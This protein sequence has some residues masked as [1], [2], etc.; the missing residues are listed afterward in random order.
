[1][2]HTASGTTAASERFDGPD[3]SVLVSDASTR[4]ALHRL[5][6]VAPRSLP[7]A[8]FASAE[9]FDLWLST[10]GI[11]LHVHEPTLGDGLSSRPEAC[12][13][14][15]W[16]AV[17]GGTITN[18]WHQEVVL[19][20]PVLRRVLSML[21]GTRTVDDVGASLGQPEIARASL[22]AIARAGLLV[23]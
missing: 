23:R 7:F 15:R 21:D 16:H 4:R 20:D 9:L 5:A 19:S 6:A 22:Q 13:V 2:P 12:P 8:Q 17:H 10:G 18:R 3:G 1:V 14:A 11:D